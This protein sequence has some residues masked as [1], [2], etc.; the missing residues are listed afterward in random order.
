VKSAILDPNVSDGA[1]VGLTA[2][3]S[4]NLIQQSV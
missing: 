1:R 3:S 2:A 4:P